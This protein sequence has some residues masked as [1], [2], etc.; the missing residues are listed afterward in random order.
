MT[1][2]R[3]VIPNPSEGRVR[4]LLFARMNRTLPSDAFDPDLDSDL[5]L[6]PEGH[7]FSRADKPPI[8]STR[9][10]PLRGEKGMSFRI[11]PKDG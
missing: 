9:L 6:N 3:D 10:Q 1:R 5:D 7:G 8:R 4:N 2:K 11:R